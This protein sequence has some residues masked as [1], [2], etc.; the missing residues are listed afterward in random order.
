MDEVVD[1]ATD[2][3][4]GESYLGEGML[5]SKGNS[6]ASAN[7]TLRDGKEAIWANG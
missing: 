2:V 3:V 1:G 5:R 6:L 4:I 7:C